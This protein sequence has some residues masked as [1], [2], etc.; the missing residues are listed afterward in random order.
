M[1][2]PNARMMI[3]QGVRMLLPCLT[4]SG[5]AA[6][7]KNS[8]AAERAAWRPNS[9]SHQ[10]N[11]A[12]DASYPALPHTNPKAC[13]C[14][15]AGTPDKLQLQS[16]TWLRPHPCAARNA[17]SN[18]GAATATVYMVYNKAYGQPGTTCSMLTAC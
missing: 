1:N 11:S 13:Y 4:T 18:N 14:L 3:K 17:A 7:L 15:L 9:L 10:M 12:S 16:L 8:F 6:G 2:T 5:L